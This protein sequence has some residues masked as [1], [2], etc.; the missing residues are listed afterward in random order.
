MRSIRWLDGPGGSGANSCGRLSE[1]C[2]SENDRGTSRRSSPKDIK[3]KRP[4]SNK[5][6]RMPS[7]PKL[8]R[9]GHCG[10]GM[11]EER[12]YRRGDVL[13]VALPLVSDPAQ[14]KIR[15]VVVIQNNVGNRFSPNL[16]VAAISSQ[17]PPRD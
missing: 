7:T 17:I 11:S 6:R 10:R 9:R 4:A 13:L 2:W 15:P 16:I 14:R 1:S 8:L 12:P 3:P 5:R